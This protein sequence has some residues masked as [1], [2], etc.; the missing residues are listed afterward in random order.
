MKKNLLTYLFI[1]VFIGYANAKS[2][3]QLTAPVFSLFNKT[4]IS[5]ENNN[6]DYKQFFLMDNS[7]V[8]ISNRNLFGKNKI[9]IYEAVSLV[10]SQTSGGMGLQI[11]MGSVLN[12]FDRELL[13]INGCLGPH[14]QFYSDGVVLGGE[15]DL[16][17]KFT[18]N[19]RCSPVIGTIINLDFYSSQKIIEVKRGTKKIYTKYG[20][21]ELVEYYEY[22]ETIERKINRFLHFYVEPY[23]AFCI[24]LY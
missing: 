3:L 22:Y 23:I 8:R 4:E 15:A 20:S 18:P 16:Q 5:A 12:I 6:L 17:L 21:V 13:C 9:G 1:L 7:I 10:M 19:R 2:D 11:A 14:L 24:N